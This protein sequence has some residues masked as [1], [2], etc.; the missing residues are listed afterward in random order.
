[1]AEQKRTHASGMSDSSKTELSRPRREKRELPE[2]W[3]VLTANADYYCNEE[4]ETIL[5]FATL[6]NHRQRYLMFRATNGYNRGDVHYVPFANV[7]GIV[8]VE[9]KTV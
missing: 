9:A 1:M 5:A 6:A 4:P 8:H 3:R 2:R 7:L